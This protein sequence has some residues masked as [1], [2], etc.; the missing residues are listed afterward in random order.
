MCRK[1][2]LAAIVAGTVVFASCQ[3]SPE[4]AGTPAPPQVEA[5][6]TVA[7]TE[8]PTVDATGNVFFTET[9]NKRIMRLS[10]DGKL[11]VFRENSNGANGLIFDAQGQ[12]AA[13]EGDP[14]A[15]RVTR[16]DVR[17]GKIEV[18]ADRHQGKRFRAPN[19]LTIDNQG[20]IYFTDQNRGGPD[21]DRVDTCGVYRIDPNG[22]LTRILASP[23]IQVPNGI[24]ISPDD[25][26][27]YL[28]ESNG[29]AGGA[30]MLRAYDLQPDGSVRNM[31]VFHNF[32]PGR[33]ADGLAMDSQG[34]LYAAAGL[35]RTRGTSETLD[36]K[37]GVYV[38]SPA[39]EQLRFIPIPEDTLTNLAFGGSDMKTLYIT[40]GK[41][42]FQT[43]VD[44]PGTP[45]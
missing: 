7:F 34:N 43:R 28:V 14:S 4:S 39:G 16:T 5:A 1:G 22:A 45:R 15:A 32:Y 24:Q 42:L 31:R 37:C 20:R 8:G 9:T 33:S 23:D 12:L 21:P 35:N 30:R 6:A 3:R 44:V 25:H 38:F 18:L 19:D 17:T 11:S 27:L 13:C 10:T 26:T 41:T 29:A 40:A 36:T 2:P